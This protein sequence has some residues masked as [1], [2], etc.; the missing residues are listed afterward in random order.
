VAS[1]GAADEDQIV[2]EDHREQVRLARARVHLVHR[3]GST[4]P[5]HGGAIVK[6]PPGGR[7]HLRIALLV[8]GVE[9]EQQV[10]GVL[11]ASLGERVVD[12]AQP[13]CGGRWTG[14]FRERPTKV[15][16]CGTG[17]GLPM[18]PDE[19][20]RPAVDRTLADTGPR[21]R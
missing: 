15:R 1:L 14:V 18:S 9:E 5:A 12:H 3:G 20:R 4:N 7:R 8:E 2:L 6:G 19:R 11:G 10:A 21:L 16:D 13:R 17:Q